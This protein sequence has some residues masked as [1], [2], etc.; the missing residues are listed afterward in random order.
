MKSKIYIVN[1]VKTKRVIFHYDF[2][3]TLEHNI[4]NK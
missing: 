2:R 1:T 4:L 3:S